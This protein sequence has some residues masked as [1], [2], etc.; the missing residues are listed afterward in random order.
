MTKL[1]RR[2]ISLAAA[3]AL[4]L[5]LAL[6]HEGHDHGKIEAKGIRMDEQGRLVL[7]P[8]ARKAIGL[9]TA[10]VDMD[11]VEETLPVNARVVL[12]W[13]G[14]AFASTRVEGVVR[15][16]LVR[17]GHEVKAGEPLALVDSLPLEALRLDERQARIE[18]ALAEENLARAQAL[19]ESVVAGNE[20]LVL[21]VERDDRKNALETATR[22]LELIG[23][24]GDEEAVVAVRAPRDGVVVD[25]DALVGE[26]VTPDE[27]LFELQ[28]LAALWL[29][30]EVPE[31]FVARVQV[32]Q[33]V[34]ASFTGVPGRTFS[35]TVELA[36]FELDED[37]HARRAYVRVDNADHALLP[38]MFGTADVVLRRAEGA[39]LAP[40]AGIVVDGAERYAFVQDGEATFRKQNVVVG[41]RSGAR[42]EI[43]EGLYPGDAVAT[44]GSHELSALFT[45]GTVKL[46]EEA[47]KNAALDVQEIDF[48][49]IDRVVKVNGRVV[50]PVGHLGVAS[51]RI[52]G[53][54][55]AILVQLGESVEAGQP[56][57]HLESLEVQGLQLDLIQ[58]QRRRALVQRQLGLLETLVARGVPPRKELSAL[59]SEAALL[60]SRTLALRRRLESTGI[61]EARLDA[62]TASGQGD[63]LVTVRAPIAGVVAHIDAALGQVLAAGAAPFKVLDPSRVWVEG[64]FFERDMAVIREGAADKPTVVR[65]VVHGE[66]AWAAPLSFVERS[67]TTGGDVL[68]GWVALDNPDG[69]LLPNMQASLWITLE[70]PAEKVVAVPLSSLLTIGARRYVFV[71][72][73][74]GFKRV[75]VELGR[76]D[77]TLVE[78][79]R[80][81]F[82]GDRVVMAGMNEINNAL[83]AVR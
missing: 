19:G 3:A 66:R 7:E 17:P 43:L 4:G 53:K 77:A 65:T 57:A 28:D 29:E 52:E 38:G 8:P 45:R 56:L 51:A 60:E 71:E 70:T 78:V 22:R 12:P 14:R 11:T 48:A 25:V 27:H 72:R 36:A 33:E 82:P 21:E 18:L 69:A 5:G 76:R 63:A 34:R 32:G 10:Q 61:D 49:T 54:V 42:L 31:T 39:F 50:A 20:L 26:H 9:A 79:R 13:F 74:D 55:A 44:D 75:Q 1:S 62:A 30:L 23:D 40:A 64:D 81:L 41:A 73:P 37:A 24:P 59:K 68:H 67:L 83:A 16:V 2:M 46:S 47:R 58:L 15:Q 80:G 6:A 35:G